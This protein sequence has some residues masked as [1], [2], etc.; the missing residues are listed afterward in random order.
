M[1]GNRVI[2]AW[3]SVCPESHGVW[4]K[5]YIEPHMRETRSRVQG[6][7]EEAFRMHNV[8]SKCMQGYG[9]LVTERYH[10][11]SHFISGQSLDGD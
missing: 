7:P 3:S 9:T 6:I 11:T 4:D 5:I 2:N 8:A 10:R 1:L